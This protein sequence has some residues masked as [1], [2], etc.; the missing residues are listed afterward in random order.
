MHLIQAVTVGDV[1]KI[2]PLEI[3]GYEMLLTSITNAEE[4]IE[5]IDLNKRFESFIEPFFGDP[6]GSD[7]KSTVTKRQL[8]LLSF[9]AVKPFASNL[10]LCSLQFL[11]L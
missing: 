4:E 2:N 11:Y 1:T 7:C 6:W 8:D 9:V 10:P 5:E 3:L